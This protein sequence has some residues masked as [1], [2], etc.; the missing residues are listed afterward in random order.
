MIRC[1]YLCLIAL[2]PLFATGKS[3]Q[4]T[5]K[6]NWVNGY[7][8]ELTNSYIEVVS[9]FDYDLKGA[10]DKAVKEVISRRSLATGAGATVTISNNNVSV[11]SDHDL[12][13][14][15]RIIDEYVHHTTGGYT[16]YLLVQ[17]AKNPTLDYE[18]V[19]VTNEYRFS[20]RAFVPGMAQIYKGSKGKGAT[21]IAT[22]AAAVAGI[23]ICENQR[24]SYI[25][26][27]K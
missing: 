12:I 7:F 18:S 17:T 10:K 27:M 14:K 20:A 16:A 15:A 21:I 25:K 26:K 8:R 1:I 5:K 19:S 11:I 13:V 4:Q 23:I 6:P 22:E 3:Y 2:F 24:A 9:A